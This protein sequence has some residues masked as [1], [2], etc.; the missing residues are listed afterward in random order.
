MDR[1][2]GRHILVTGGAGY[3]GSVLVGCLLRRGDWVTV[4]DDLLFGGESLLAYLG[5]PAFHFVR[6]DVCR[7]GAVQEAAQEA[8]ARGAPSP[9]AV[10]HLAAL[11]GFPACQAAGREMAWSVNVDGLRRVFE[12]AESLGAERLVFS[13]TYSNYGL[14]QDGVPVTEDSPLNP[15]SLYAET[16]IAAEEYLLGQTGGARCSPLIFRFATLFGVSPRMRFDLIVNQFVLE[17]FR[18]GELMIYQRQYARSFVHVRDIA[19]GVMLGLDAPEDRIRGQVYNLGSDE[20]NFTKDEI[21]AF[22]REAL[23]GTK[24]RYE[25]RNYDGDLRDVRVSFDKVR[26]RLAFEAKVSVREGIGE[27]LALLQSG[28]IPDPESDRFRSAR[29]IVFQESQG[30]REGWHER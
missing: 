26:A 16:K 8:I 23:P 20:N 17:A 4:I 12:D 11:A 5:D 27:V 28:L 22:I 15:Q 2:S 7:P 29:P 10:V 21:G 19:A 1:R 9:S 18:R 24:V 25:D 14:A 6:A 30:E 3:I 13:S